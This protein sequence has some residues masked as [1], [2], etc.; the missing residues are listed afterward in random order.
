MHDENL[1]NAVKLREARIKR[2]NDLVGDDSLLR[3]ADGAA[4]EVLLDSDIILM[5]ADVKEVLKP[6]A[7]YIC[8][9][10]FTKLHFYYDALCPA[11]AATNFMKRNLLV[12]L[13]A[14]CTAILTGGR[15]KIGFHVGLKL[16]RSGA[17]LIV[18]S[19][20]PVDCVKRYQKEADF[21]SWKDRLH[22]YGLDFRAPRMLELWCDHVVKEFGAI[23]SKSYVHSNSIQFQ[24]YRV[25][26]P[27]TLVLFIPLTITIHLILFLFGE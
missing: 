22:I 7:C 8:K 11:C 19:R 14:G 16:L 9:Q 18:T 21:D 24:Q 15:V 5:E 2:K 17:K 13:P 10:R 23:D 20:F 27:D 12:D 6:K 1:I 3:I 25:S 4:V 26:G